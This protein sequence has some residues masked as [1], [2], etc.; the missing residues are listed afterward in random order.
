MPRMFDSGI[1]G[2][3][4]SYGRDIGALSNSQQM[5]DAPSFQDPKN[6]NPQSQGIN[7]LTKR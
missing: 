6:R 1:G 2:R 7:P 4:S 5:P 3:Q